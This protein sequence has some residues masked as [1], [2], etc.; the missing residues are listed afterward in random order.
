MR[1][2]YLPWIRARAWVK[3]ES[4]SRVVVSKRMASG[5]MAVGAVV[6]VESAWSRAARSSLTCCRVK[7]SPRDN[8]SVWRRV[9]RASSE[10]VT[11]I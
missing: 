6:R 5:A 11:K 1:V 4:M 9:A 10:A 2:G 8:S 3:A 7:V